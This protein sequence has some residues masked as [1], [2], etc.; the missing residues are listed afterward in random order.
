[1]PLTS[2]ETLQLLDRLAKEHRINFAGDLPQSKWPNC[3]KKT[4]EGITELGERKFDLFATEPNVTSDEPWKVQAKSQ[5]A[6]LVEK[7]RRSRQRNESSWR[8][9]CEPLIFARLEAEVVWYHS[10]PTSSVTIRPSLAANHC[11]A[12]VA[13]SEYG[14]PKSRQVEKNHLLQQKHYKGGSGIGSHVDVREWHV[15][16]TSKRSD[17]VIWRKKAPAMVDLAIFLV[18]KQLG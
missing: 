12:R 14:A 7:A 18:S 3:H 8:F 13:G 6:L 10:I 1:M 16:R 15:T 17:P 11:E 5:A 4:L 9:A 2:T